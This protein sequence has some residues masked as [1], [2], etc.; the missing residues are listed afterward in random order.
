M[1]IYINIYKKKIKPS[2]R[3]FHRLNTVCHGALCF[4]S[5][6]KFPTHHCNPVCQTRV[7]SFVRVWAYSKV[8]FH[9]QSPSHLRWCV[10]V[11]EP[12]SSESR[13]IFNIYL[14]HR[15]LCLFENHLRLP[16][17][18]DSPAEFRFIPT[19]RCLCVVWPVLV[20]LKSGAGSSIY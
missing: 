19:E 2:A 9:L 10:S 6:C 20:T 17:A 3:C 13:V 8:K 5:G 4:M 7:T 11:L 1:Y 18:N 12:Q 15:G 16:A 14:S